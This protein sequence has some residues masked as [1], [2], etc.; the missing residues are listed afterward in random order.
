[1]SK[2][3]GHQN[4]NIVEVKNNK[5]ALLFAFGAGVTVGAAGLYAY[6]NRQRIAEMLE[7]KVRIVD[8]DDDI[9]DEDEDT[10]APTTEDPNVEF[11]MS[12]EDEQDLYSDD[13]SN[14]NLTDEQFQSVVNSSDEK[15]VE[16]GDDENA[17]FISDKSVEL[18]DGERISEEDSPMDPVQEETPEEVP[19]VV[20]AEPEPEVVVEEKRAP[21]KKTN[22]ELTLDLLKTIEEAKGSPSA[23]RL[24]F[25]EEELETFN[26]PKNLKAQVTRELNALKD[27]VNRI[28]AEA[29]ATEALTVDRA[30]SAVFNVKELMEAG[31]PKEAHELF[32]REL[33]PFLANEEFLADKS[34]ED[35]TKEIFHLEE[36]TRETVI[37][38]TL[39]RS[40][41]KGK[42]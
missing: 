21:K 7:N 29:A 39:E 17:D 8:A 9:C 19:E 27:L 37:S 36:L 13:F 38:A 24:A 34:H 32:R 12:E 31:R 6:Q 22:R 15:I 3:Y 14:W 2:K 42:Y 4:G 30:K 20:T 35:L 5:G 33:T 11:R 40:R 16:E 18:S 41:Y 28:Q 26:V 1:M 25:I 10:D 23:D